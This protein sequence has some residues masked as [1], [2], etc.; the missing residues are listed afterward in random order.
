MIEV[1]D[2]VSMA[3]KGIIDPPN[4]TWTCG[5]CQQQ[6]SDRQDL[7]HPGPAPTCDICGSRMSGAFT[8]HSEPKSSAMITKKY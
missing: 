3:V 6:I 8:I 5:K 7:R 4:W 1:F 2:N